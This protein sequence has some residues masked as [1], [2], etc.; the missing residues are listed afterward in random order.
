MSTEKAGDELVARRRRDR[1]AVRDLRVRQRLSPVARADEGLARRVVDHAA[2]RVAVGVSRRRDRVRRAVREL[3]ARDQLDLLDRLA[4]REDVPRRV[5][6]EGDV[7]RVDDR[8]DRERDQEHRPGDEE[9]RRQQLLVRDQVDRVDRGRRQR[10]APGAAPTCGALART[11]AAQT[12]IALKPP[13]R[14]IF[15]MSPFVPEKNAISRAGSDRALA[16]LKCGVC[17]SGGWD[18]CVAHRARGI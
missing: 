7:D 17:D 5:V 4:L 16:L 15:A 9:L 11:V 12:T 10:D 14:T 8:D 6:R 13:S 18:G 2:G 3:S 1:R